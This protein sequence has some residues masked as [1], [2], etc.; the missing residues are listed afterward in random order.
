MWWISAI[1]AACAI[2][3]S[4]F[5]GSLYAQVKATGHVFAEVVESLSASMNSRQM[6]YVDRTNNAEELELGEL[7]INGGALEAY[8]LILISDRLAEES[9]THATF[10][11][12]T[13]H[14]LTSKVF[15]YNGKQVFRLFGSFYK[16][17][18]SGIELNRRAA[19]QITFAYN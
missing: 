11:A 2:V 18:Q 1:I 3:A 10:L 19:F 14:R 12:I 16:P 17:N 8:D 9:V 6:V 13:D 15:D 5:A 7:V 4:S